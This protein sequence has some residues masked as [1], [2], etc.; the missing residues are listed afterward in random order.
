MQSKAATVKEYLA[1]LPEDRR[2]DLEALR[3]V[4]LANLDKDFQES[5]G[6][7]MAGYCVPHSVY[8]PGYHCDPKQPLPFAGFASQK[9]SMSL[10]L[11]GL[12]M[13]KAE[14]EW[15]EKA[16]K[17]SGKKLDAGKS[18]IRF[19]KIDDL[20][21]DV[22]GE[23]FKRMPAKKYIALYEGILGDRKHP[24]KVANGDGGAAPAKKSAAKPANK[25]EAA[26]KK[27]S[28]K[29]TGKKPTLRK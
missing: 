24:G 17:K 5:M 20:A 7:G 4:I 14:R 6:Y 22:I 19:K 8:P 3:K 28:G 18:C 26:Y 1:S 11:M 10:Y 25:P 9:N 23:A 12:Y 21:L 13:D 29:K 16:W 15:F 27:K 2:K